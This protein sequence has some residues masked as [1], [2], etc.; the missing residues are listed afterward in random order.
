MVLASLHLHLTYD[1][2]DIAEAVGDGAAQ[3]H[4][5]SVILQEDLLF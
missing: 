4:F 5:A 2:L 3:Q 1:S